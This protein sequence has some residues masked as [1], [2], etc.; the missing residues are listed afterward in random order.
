MIGKLVL[1]FLI[2]IL[3]IAVAIPIFVDISAQP[4]GAVWIENIDMKLLNVN[5]SHAVL[6]FSLK[7]SKETK[8]EI[9]TKIYDSMTNILLKETLIRAEGKECNATLTLE[10]DR[11]YN[12]IFQLISNGEVLDRRGL[13]VRGLS[14]L[15]PAELELKLELKDVDFRVT[16]LLD[17][18][19]EVRATLYL[20][21]MRDYDD[22]LFHLKAIQF[23]SGILADERWLLKALR[24]GKTEIVEINV[25]VPLDYNYLIKIEAWRSETLLKSWS[26]TL[27]LAPT[28]K[29]PENYKEERVKFEVTDFLKE[30]PV[31]TPYT[32]TAKIPGFEVLFALAALG[33]VALW[34]KRR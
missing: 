29:I 27:N 15:L 26:K 14:T 34:L 28:K 4:P 2:A 32:P 12:V 11:D 30:A 7:L 6:V 16:R 17:G 19:V 33:G 25:T 13:N 18:N 9:L 23:D 22:V 31:S 20:E 10:K 5:E 21:S 24:S 8:A 3:I 1:T